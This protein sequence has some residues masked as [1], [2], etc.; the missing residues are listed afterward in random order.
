M[1]RILFI[2]G[3]C[4]LAIGLNAQISISE[5]DKAFK[6][7]ANN[8]PAPN[9]EFTSKCGEVNVEIS[10]RMASGGC[11]GNLIRTYKATDS[12]GNEA[13]AEQYLSLQDTKGPYIYGAP[14]DVTVSKDAI[15]VLPVVGAKDLGDDVIEVTVSETRAGETLIRT[16]KAVDKCGNKSEKSQRITLR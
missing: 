3:I 14:E 1:K 15:P 2:L 13:G 10:E 8:V 16:W 4:T 11:I 5:Y 6:V 7:N 9:V 12:C